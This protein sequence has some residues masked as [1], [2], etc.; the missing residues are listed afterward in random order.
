MFR[1]RAISMGRG[2]LEHRKRDSPILQT[3]MR[4]DRPPYDLSHHVLPA[5]QKQHVRHDE[6]IRYHNKPPHSD[7]VHHPLI[8][9]I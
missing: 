9:Q 1:E 8:L 3:F 7:L 2:I 4:G 6:T 5:K